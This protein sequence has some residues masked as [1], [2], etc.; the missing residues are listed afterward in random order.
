M[1]SI[2]CL[3]PRAHLGFVFRQF[4]S[5]RNPR[6]GRKEGRVVPKHSRHRQGY[7]EKEEAAEL[8]RRRELQRRAAELIDEEAETSLLQS[9]IPP[10]HIRLA[11]QVPLRTAFSDGF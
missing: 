9:T 6:G 1:R 4:L 8:A 10:H 11:F 3:R 7:C 2:E 5:P